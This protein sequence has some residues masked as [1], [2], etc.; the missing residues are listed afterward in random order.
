LDCDAARRRSADERGYEPGSIVHHI[1]AFN[2]RFRKLLWLT[3]VVCER[4]GAHADSKEPRADPRK[5]DEQ[6]DLSE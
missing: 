5:G 3:T 2:D 4:D 6:G 1:A